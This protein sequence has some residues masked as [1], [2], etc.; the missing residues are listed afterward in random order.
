MLIPAEYTLPL[1]RGGT[2]R[3]PLD[4]TNP[5]GTPMNLTGAKV[6]FW[7]VAGASAPTPDIE[8]SSEFPDEIS[9]EPLDGYFEVVLPFDQTQTLDKSPYYRLLIDWPNGD[10]DV[11]LYGKIT[12][13]VGLPNG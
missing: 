5:D 9:V 4:L 13:L 7:V 3:W 8:L 2:L 10:R 12:F 6:R 1:V 11:L